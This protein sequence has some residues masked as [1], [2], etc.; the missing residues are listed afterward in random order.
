MDRHGADQDSLPRPQV[1]TPPDDRGF[2]IG[3]P[4]ADRNSKTRCHR[5]RAAALR[6]I[7]I[8]LRTRSRTLVEERGGWARGCRHNRSAAISRLLAGCGPRRIWRGP[9]RIVINAG[10]E[11][12]AAVAWRFILVHPAGP[13]GFVLGAMR[14]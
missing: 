5:P 7:G 9:Y 12:P 14:V 6:K 11:K 10:S 2:E 13:R 3:R 1:C 8:P 4:D